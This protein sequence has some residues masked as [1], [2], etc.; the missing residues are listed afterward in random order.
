MSSPTVPFYPM[1]HDDAEDQNVLLGEI[2]DAIITGMDQSILAENFSAGNSYVIGDYVNYS[3]KLYR[4]T[5]AHTGPWSDAD[6]EEVNVGEELTNLNVGKSDV[7]HVHDD[8]YYTEAE[9]DALLDGKSDVGHTHDDRYYTETET[10]TLL[11]GK[12]D[13]GHDH[14]TRYYTKTDMDT[15]LAGKSDISH[16]HDDRY[17]TETEVDSAL[18]GKSDT[19]HTHDERY[20]TETETD[21]ILAGK[22]DISHTHDDRY[23]TETEMDTAL[24]DKADAD[25]VYSKDETDAL[26]TDKADVITRTVSGSIVTLTDAANA[27][28]ADLNVAIEPVQDLHGQTNPYPAGGGKNLIDFDTTVYTSNV[29]NVSN[30]VINAKTGDNFY[31]Y[32]I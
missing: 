3:K 21:I 27:P 16:T 13:V 22:S 8:R 20:Y 25:D 9:S 26:L 14:D 4:F 30:N 5:S 2:R 15:A 6:A 12:S 17:Y 11:D 10:D 24:A 32:I 31:I 23:Y 19:D 29:S 18:A 7:G 28:V 1:T